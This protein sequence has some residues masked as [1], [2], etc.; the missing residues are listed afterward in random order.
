MKRA[1]LAL[2]AFLGVACIAAAIAIPTYLVPKLKVVPLDLDITSVATSVAGDGDAG[3]RFPATILDRCSITKSRA[4]TLQAHLTQ[5]RRSVI[6]DPSDAEQA[7]LQSGQT[8]QI[9]RVRDAKGK[10]REVTMASGDA[11]RKCDDGLLNATVDRVSV[12]RKSSAPNGNISS[13]QTDPVAEGGNIDEASVKLEDRKGFQYKFGFDVK[14]TDYYYYDTTTRQDAIA[15]FVEEKTIN[16]VKTYHFRAEVAER[17]LSDLPNPQG[18]ATLGTILNMPAKWWGIRGK[19]VK[20]RDVITMHRYAKAVRNVY[21]EPTTGTIIFG[22]EEQE[23]YFRSPDDSEDVPKAIKDYRL[24]AMQGTFAWNDE[25]VAQQAERADKYLGQL[26]LGG[27]IAPIVLAVLGVLLLLAW[28]LLIWRGRRGKNDADPETAPV[29]DDGGDATEAA[30]PAEETTVIPPTAA[31]MPYDS[32]DDGQTTVLPPLPDESSTQAIP[33]VHDAP[34][35]PPT[36]TFPSPY[37]RP[38]PEVQSPADVTDTE[39]FR[40]PEAP[41][42]GFT[43]YTGEPTRPMPDFDKYKRDQ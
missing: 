42:D 27:V 18:E 7:T 3:N 4:A 32:A 20:S 21:V 25:T 38:D 22:E 39:A 2:L 31:A 19:G 10:E 8:L 5:Q 23:Q 12:N 29:P 26:R 24:T 35:D 13:L 41:A 9:D 16:G 1:A 43:P 11:E 36:E 28:A 14:K 15:K 40:A 30:T 6:V 37:A 17:D 33:T 34:Q